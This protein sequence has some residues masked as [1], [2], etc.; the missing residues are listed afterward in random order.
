VGVPV[1]VLS[2]LNSVEAGDAKMHCHQTFSLFCCHDR[3]IL[4]VE[5]N[6]EHQKA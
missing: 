5:A 2:V 1:S 6:E 4:N 3:F